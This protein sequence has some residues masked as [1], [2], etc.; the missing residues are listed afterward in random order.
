MP[1]QASATSFG[2]TPGHYGPLACGCLMVVVPFDP[3]GPRL[4]IVGGPHKHG[5][6]NAKAEFP[7]AWS[8]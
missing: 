6:M 8:A 4:V 2:C 1:Y 7:E 3:V 5:M